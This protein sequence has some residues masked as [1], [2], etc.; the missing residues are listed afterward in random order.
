MASKKSPEAGAIASEVTPVGKIKGSEFQVV[1][2][3][4]EPCNV[5]TGE[6]DLD[7][8]VGVEVRIDPVTGELKGVEV[9]YL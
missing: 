6:A 3:D 5:F 2:D 8:L 9:R 7:G 1:Y 4:T